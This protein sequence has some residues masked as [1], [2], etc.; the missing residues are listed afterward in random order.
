MEL[1][2]KGRIVMVTSLEMPNEAAKE[3]KLGMGGTGKHR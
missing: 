3:A 2:T 1:L